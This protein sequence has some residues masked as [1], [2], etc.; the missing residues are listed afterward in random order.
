[1][2]TM[3]TKGGFSLVEL[4]TVI[5]IIAIL[6]GIIF[7]TM[8]LVKNKAKTTKCMTNLYN[9]SVALKAFKQDNGRFPTSLGGYVQRDTSGN[10]IPFERTKGDAL[11]P[12]YTKGGSGVTTFHCPLSLT[13]ATDAVLQAPAAGNTTAEYYAYDSYDVYYGNVANSGTTVTATGNDVR[14]TLEWAP[15][16]NDVDAFAPYPPGTQASAD[17]TD[18]D[19]DRQLK[20]RY[21]SD[22]TVVTWCTFHEKIGDNKSKIPVLFLSG[23]CDMMPANE[24]NQSKWRTQPK[25]G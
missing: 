24:V 21:P 3:R 17:L 4:L 11:Y 16:K 1:M 22:D 6:A 23:Q 5:A 14:Y 10:V 9:I 2:K 15:T 18:Y 7:P 12:E 13:I 8:I 19:F 25:K 20:F